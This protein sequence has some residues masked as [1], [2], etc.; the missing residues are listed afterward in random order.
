MGC[1]RRWGGLFEF[2]GDCQSL[3]FV[4]ED[5]EDEGEFFEK[6]PRVKRWSLCLLHDEEERQKKRSSLKKLVSRKED[7]K[8]RK[9]GET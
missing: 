5:D 6:C 1:R 7:K 2:D 8:R 3:V 4:F 9:K